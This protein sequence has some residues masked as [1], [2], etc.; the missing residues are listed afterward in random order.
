MTFGQ[1]VRELRTAKKL[2][3][4]ALA[5]KVGVGFTYLSRV[6]N[7]KLDF[8]D[9]VARLL[10]RRVGKGSRMPTRTSCSVPC[11]EDSRDRSRAIH[12]AARRL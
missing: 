11:R 7:S 2:S 1:R 9:S 4:R 12:R 5:P 6:E 3:L 10:I 8:G